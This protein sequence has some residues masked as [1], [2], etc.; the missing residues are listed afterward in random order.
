MLMCGPKTDKPFGFLYR[1]H[2]VRAR[3][4]LA[5]F[6]VRHMDTADKVENGELRCDSHG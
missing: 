1:N 5:D 2:A 4:L 3:Q 6:A